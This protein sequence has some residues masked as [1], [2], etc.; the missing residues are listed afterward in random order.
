MTNTPEASAV[1]LFL[2]ST[3]TGPF[4]WD[5]VPAEVTAGT[6]RLAPTN[7]GY[8]PHPPVTRGT[9][10]TAQDD[11]E[12]ALSAIGPEVRAV[13]VY[14]HSYGGLVA[15]R[16]LPMLGARVRSLFLAE[17]V[18][19][20]ALAHDA[21]ADADAA[22]EARTFLAHPWFL[23][24][25]A[26]AG[27]DEWLETFIDYWNRPGSWSRLPPDMQAYSRAAS[28]KMVQEVRSCFHDVGS[29]DE[30]RLPDVPT[31]LVMGE[32]STPA[33]RAMTKTQA[34]RH[35]KATLVELPRAG[36]MAPLT[37]SALLHEAMLA[38]RAR[39]S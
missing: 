18:V 5:G 32:R 17:P 10:V 1:S 38:H 19:F 13:D 12:N 8:P 14:A 25:D 27:S 28:W 39:L 2:H 29:F 35:P 7:L 30:V 20:G 9:R 24:D 11:A 6:T 4:L 36:H 22:R 15:I 34:A 3:G 33:S 31:T 37:H 16:L 21:D 26:R 23:D